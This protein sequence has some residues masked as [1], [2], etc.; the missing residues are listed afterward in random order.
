MIYT[1]FLDVDTILSNIINASSILACEISNNFLILRIL[2]TL[3]L[4]YLQSLI[5][6]FIQYNEFSTE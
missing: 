2:I 6:S 3:S 5:Y 1:S 4:Q